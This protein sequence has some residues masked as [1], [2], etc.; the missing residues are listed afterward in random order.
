MSNIEDDIDPEWRQ[1]MRSKAK[2]RV[3]IVGI[4]LFGVLSWFG[5]IYGAAT[6]SRRA[7]V[8]ATQMLGLPQTGEKL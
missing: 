1:F 5:C 4:I 2:N 7:T 3:I 8:A 6:L